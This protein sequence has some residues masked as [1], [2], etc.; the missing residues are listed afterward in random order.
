MNFGFLNGQYLLGLYD[1]MSGSNVIINGK[2]S[3]LEEMNRIY[4]IDQA[5]IP[6]EECKEK[7]KLLYE[8][9]SWTLSFMS[10]ESLTVDDSFD[11]G[12]VLW[13]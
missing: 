11:F 10:G 7:M 13:N 9:G 8:D 12:R 2:I 6:E 4:P 5:E 1:E 3:T